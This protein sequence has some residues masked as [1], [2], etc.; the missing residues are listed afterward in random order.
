MLCFVLHKL[1]LNE[2]YCVY[3]C[4]CVCMCLSVCMSVCLS[5]CTH[6]LM[7]CVCVCGFYKVLRFPNDN[8]VSICVRVL[9]ITRTNVHVRFLDNMYMYTVHESSRF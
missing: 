7:G 3:L 6:M 5:V 2:P 9:D 8:D 1:I 4:V